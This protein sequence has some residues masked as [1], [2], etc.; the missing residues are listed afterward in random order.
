[1]KA[2]D[3]TGNH[4]KDDDKITSFIISQKIVNDYNASTFNKEWNTAAIN[5]RWEWFC[6]QVS[7]EFQIDL[8]EIKSNIIV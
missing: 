4:S 1:M 8:N 6:D 3:G 2:Y 7:H 5:K